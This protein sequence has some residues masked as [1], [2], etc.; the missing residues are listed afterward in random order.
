MNNS[1]SNKFNFF[2]EKF[3][4]GLLI[5][6][7]ILC[8]VQ[9]GILWSYQ[10]LSSPI[11]LFFNSNSK[12]NSPISID[13]SKGEYLL[14]YRIAISTG[15][16]GEHYVIP[17][18][19]KEYTTLWNGAKQYIDQALETKPQNI[20][21]FNE[22]DWGTLV[23]NKP[24]MFEFKTPIPIDIVKWTLDLEDYKGEGLPSIYKMVICPDDSDNGYAD[25]LYIRDD[26]KI[27]TYGIK[28]IENN[29]LSY[30]VFNEI[31]ASQKS[32]NNS[33]SYQMAIEKYRKFD[34]SKDMISVFSGQKQE[35]LPN[36]TCETIRGLDKEEYTYDDFYDM[37]LDLFGNARIDYDF[38]VDVNGWVVFTKEDG[39]YRLYKNSILEYKYTG[40]QADTN[41]INVLEAYKKTLTCLL[42][43]K[44]QNDNI[45]FYL[46]SI[47]RKQGVYIF[48][49]DYSISLGGEKGEIPIL[50]DNYKIPNSEDVLS[51]CISIE[52]SSKK[53][54]SF[55]WLFLKFY[56]GNSFENYE[57]SFVDMYSKM[58][59]KYSG[60]KDEFSAKDFGIYYVLYESDMQEYQITPSFVIFTK[61]GTYDI[62]LEEK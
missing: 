30:S 60:M 56:V 62:L 20:Q 49:F 51:N 55:K 29:S 40:N 22:D 4:A 17:N 34:I 39:S 1:K 31:Y 23:A 54:L 12:S 25:T 15:F 48:N 58:Y 37:A 3:K 18:G 33:K 46:S 14:P 2:Y 57:W 45:T 43:N 47:N 32:A 53:V 21:P 38:D 27:Y 19:S 36:I 35:S 41:E 6:L 52:A 9:I 16:D 8:I 44:G 13:D 61:D 11:S 42:E 10:S 5:C 26:K 59:D 7:I 28:N 24:Y 50:L